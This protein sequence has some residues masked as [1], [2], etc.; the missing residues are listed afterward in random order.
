MEGRL[1]QICEEANQSIDQK[2]EIKKQLKEENAEIL[3]KIEE[4]GHLFS[5]KQEMMNTKLN[6]L[7]ARFQEH[8]VSIEGKVRELE[9]NVDDVNVKLDK[10]GQ[11]FNRLQ[12]TMRKKIKMK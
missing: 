9:K 12:E 10:L 2:K 4:E 7:N 6:Y 11:V 8:K 1:Y 3:T 5:Q